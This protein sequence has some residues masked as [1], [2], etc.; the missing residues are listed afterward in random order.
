MTKETDE[1]YRLQQYL[2]WK[3]GWEAVY[4]ALTQE[5]R[6]K[7]FKRLQKEIEEWERN[8]GDFER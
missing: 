4:Y 8:K 2:K 7:L 6:H 1:E 3:G 5:E